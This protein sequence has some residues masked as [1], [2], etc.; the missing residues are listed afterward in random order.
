MISLEEGVKITKT[1]FFVDSHAELFFTF[2]SQKNFILKGLNWVGSLPCSTEHSEFGKKYKL[3]RLDTE[4]KNFIKFFDDFMQNKNL[5]IMFF[6]SI[7]TLGLDFNIPYFN[8]AGNNAFKA[9]YNMGFI[10]HE[11]LDINNIYESTFYST[12]TLEPYIKKNIPINDS[13]NSKEEL[14]SLFLC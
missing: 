7:D 13:I 2:N 14:D 3:C 11:S 6:F 5:S 9:L 4:T 10:I 8:R 1:I 12:C